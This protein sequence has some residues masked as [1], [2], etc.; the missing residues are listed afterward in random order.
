MASAA[1]ECYS[2]AVDACEDVLNGTKSLLWRVAVILRG[3]WMS[4]VRPTLLVFCWFPV[5]SSD[6]GLPMGAFANCVVDL[7]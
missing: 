7:G 3:W 4:P 6:A 5:E 2:V 1:R